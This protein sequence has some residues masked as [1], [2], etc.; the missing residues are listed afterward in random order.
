MTHPEIPRELSHHELYERCV[1]SPK[2]LPPL[3]RAIHGGDPTRL[4]EDFCG[5]A[6]LSK[7]W[8][9]QVPDA[10]ATA[11]DRD[12]DPLAVAR[13]DAPANLAV[14]EGDVFE[15]TRPAAAH[16]ADVIFVGNFSIG[17]IHE[18][19]RLVEYLRHARARLAPGGVFICDTYG[20]ES[21][22]LTGAVHRN[23]PGPGG[24]TIRYT[25]E[26]READPLTG[27][28]VNALHFRLDD[29]GTITQELHDAFV[30]DWRLWSV[31]ELRDAMAEAG[32]ARAQVFAKLPDAVDDEGRVYINPVEDP[33]DLEDSFIVCVAGRTE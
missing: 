19:A 2:D 7:A 23:H 21:A 13:A 26:Q 5:T 3:L 27:R 15:A 8:C 32:F 24:T 16:P 10:S 28:V 31:P 1:Q 18:R 22:F 25:W 17:E 6:A 11:V 4:G 14:L 33:G 29:A 30:Y 20:G 12:P 9:A